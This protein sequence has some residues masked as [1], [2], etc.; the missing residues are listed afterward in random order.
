MWHVRRPR[1]LVVHIGKFLEI[2]LG[3]CENL[4]HFAERQRERDVHGH[5]SSR[6]GICRFL[7]IGQQTECGFLQK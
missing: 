1:K 6:F 3:D 5:Y 2:L 7:I 4:G